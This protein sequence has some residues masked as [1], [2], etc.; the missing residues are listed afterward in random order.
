M[1]K[2]LAMMVAG[3]RRKS[4]S[5][6]EWA[7]GL[8]IKL[9]QEQGRTRDLTAELQ[10]LGATNRGW[11]S[12]LFS[13]ASLRGNT[14]S[15]RPVPRRL[16]AVL[17]AESTPVSSPRIAR[18]VSESS[19]GTP[20]ASSAAEDTGGDQRT[21]RQRLV[22]MVEVSATMMGLNSGE[23]VLERMLAQRGRDLLRESS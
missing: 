4:T 9:E 6:A 23:S 10:A 12:D 11:G 1:E 14:E 21:L 13:G 17:T 15:L 7:S 20:R 3:E 16:S 18:V 19:P 22:G 5:H 8:Q 2:R